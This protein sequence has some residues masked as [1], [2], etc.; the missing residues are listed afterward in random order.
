LLQVLLWSCTVLQQESFQWKIEPTL[1]WEKNLNYHENILKMQKHARVQ[2]D[3]C[4]LVKSLKTHEYMC[5]HAEANAWSL[6]SFIHLNDTTSIKI[7][8]VRSQNL[9]QSV[10]MFCLGWI[11][12][13]A[14]N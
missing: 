11:N 7:Y 2:K 3:E 6:A 14:P 5:S 4:N 8:T 9:N 1:L 10:G 12:F 13:L